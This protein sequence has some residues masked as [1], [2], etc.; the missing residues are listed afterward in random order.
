MPAQKPKSRSDLTVV[1]LEGEAVIYDDATRQVHYLNP[2]ATVVF[3][4]CDGSST[5]K[6]LSADIADAF[7]LRPKEVEP[8]VRTLLRSFRQ[9]GFLEGSPAKSTSSPNGKA[10]ATGTLNGATDPT[11]HDKRP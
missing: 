9:A 5:I 2:T 3:N 10:Q 1:V 8:Q 11:E 7:S 6:E 4:L